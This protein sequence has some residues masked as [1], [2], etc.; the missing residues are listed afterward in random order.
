MNMNTFSSL[1]ILYFRFGFV[2][3]FLEKSLAFSF[4]NKYDVN[5]VFR[6]KDILVCN[7]EHNRLLELSD[8]L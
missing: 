4:N 1:K 3:E 6:Q 2:V 5:T 7:C 8:L